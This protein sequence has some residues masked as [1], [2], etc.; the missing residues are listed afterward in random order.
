MITFVMNI[1]GKE[2]FFRTKKQTNKLFLV[3]ILKKTIV[4]GMVQPAVLYNGKD[5]VAMFYHINND[6]HMIIQHEVNM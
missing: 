3:V 5:I 1:N 6:H 2:Q 4:Y